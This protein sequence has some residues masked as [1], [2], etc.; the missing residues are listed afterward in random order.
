MEEVDVPALLVSTRSSDGLRVMP[1]GTR[2]AD[3]G[4]LGW[5][6]FEGEKKYE[7]MRN[8]LHDSLPPQP[9]SLLKTKAHLSTRCGTGVCFIAVL[10]ASPESQKEQIAALRLLQGKPYYKVD[11]AALTRGSPQVTQLPVNFAWLP[12]RGQSAFLETFEC[13]STPALVAI[14]G[15]KKKYALHRGAFSV[16][17]LHEFVLSVMEGGEHLED[18]DSFPEISTP[19]VAEDTA[20]GE[21]SSKGD[22]DASPAGGMPKKLPKGARKGKGRKV[23]KVMKK[24]KKTTSKGAAKKD[25]GKEEL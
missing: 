3:L 21:R 19:L 20:G 17:D 12:A 9:L 5:Q 22:G 1:D 14:S 8:W 25:Q 6:A 23:R 11:A 18:F 7:H 16:D 2:Q 4:S 24:K 13:S 10:S 15:K